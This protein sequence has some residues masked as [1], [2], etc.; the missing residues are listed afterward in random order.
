MAE[1]GF[2]DSSSVVSTKH[3]HQNDHIYMVRAP[4]SLQAATIGPS[5][6]HFEDSVSTLLFATRA[7]AVQNAAVVNE[8]CCT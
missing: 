2:P 8:V 6:A 7:M 4:P 3:P 5:L 1:N